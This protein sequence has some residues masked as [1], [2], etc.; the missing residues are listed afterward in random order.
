MY[1][2]I[3]RTPYWYTALLKI[4]DALKSLFAF[5]T[6]PNSMFKMDY[7]THFDSWLKNCIFFMKTMS[8]KIN[9]KS[10]PPPGPQSL[11]THH[12]GGNDSSSNRLLIPGWINDC[13][14]PYQ[15]TVLCWMWELYQQLAEGIMG[16]EMRLINMIQVSS[17]VARSK[18]CLSKLLQQY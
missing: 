12:R 3:M 7:N 16:D 10:A 11:L 9:D 14:F 1:T 2:T 13:L 8:N 5:H 15:C 4:F 17:F 18:T 6:V